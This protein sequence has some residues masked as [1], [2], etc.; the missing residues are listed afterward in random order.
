MLQDLNGKTCE[1]VTGVTIGKS[2][3]IYTVKLAKL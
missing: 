3:L 1:I 2:S